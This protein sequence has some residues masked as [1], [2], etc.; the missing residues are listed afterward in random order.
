MLSDWYHPNYLALVEEDL[1]P[2]GGG[3]TSDNNLINGKMNYNC[4]N[5]NGGSQFCSN[6][7]TL[8]KFKFQRGKIHRL[9]LINSGAEALQR[10][11]IDQHKMT[12]ISNDFVAVEPYETD[13]VT[14]GI[15]QRTDVLVEANGD[16]NSYWMRSNISHPCSLSHQDFAIAAVYYDAYSTN[17]VPSSTAWDAPDPATCSNDDLEKTRPVM[18]LHVPDPDLVLIIDLDRHTNASNVGLWTL[19]GQD[20][21]INYNSPTLLLSNLGNTSFE[22][23]WNVKNLG[24]ATSV[25][26]VVNNLTPAAHPMHLH[27]FNM[28]ILH[29]GNGTWDG[30]IVRPE[31]PQRRD[32][33]Q[34]QSLGHLAMQFDAAENPGMWPFHCHIAWHV[35]AGLLIQFLTSPDEVRRM[36]VPNT[37]AETCRQW[38]RWTRTNI[39]NQIDSGL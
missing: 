7:A 2:G 36:R 16:L 31:N 8:S 38:S 24:N 34:L 13:V 3:V 25:R 37:V 6:D 10:F 9:R 19:D 17:E 23:E 4:S 1:A 12:V 15:G 28:Y 14:L 5:V 39:P 29:E 27:G 26:V 32:V 30:T 18:E 33:V 21:R 20:F 11:S 22:D 35:S